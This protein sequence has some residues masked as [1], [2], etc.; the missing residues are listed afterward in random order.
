MLF[1]FLYAASSANAGEKFRIT[2]TNAVELPS[3]SSKEAP[4]DFLPSKIS[5]G[6][7]TEA[8]NLPVPSQPG[9]VRTPALDDW[10]DRKKNWMFDTPNSLDRDQ[11]M[12]EIFGVR[13]Y[14][15]TGMEKKP[16]S[17]IQQFLE[18]DNDKKNGTNS[19]RSPDDGSMARDPLAKQH[20]I[21]SSGRYNERPE[22]QKSESVGIIPALNPAYLF[23]WR[24]G[25]DSLSQTPVE[26]GWTSVLPPALGDQGFAQKVPNTPNK[27]STQGSR[28]GGQPWDLQKMPLG[29]LNDPINDQLDGTR[30]PLNPIGAR[31]TTV[32]LGEPA[33][34]GS[35]DTLAVG[36]IAPVSSHP[37][38]FPANRSLPTA[39]SFVPSAA[40]PAQAPLV[41]ARPAV[42]DIPRPRF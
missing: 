8:P 12:H 18:S 3:D 39:P 9:L 6:E 29:R 41:Q 30:Y 2:G 16:K 20:E 5:P 35:G 21:D 11:A 27:E 42:L 4:R 38:L 14:E 22:T 31:K 19:K 40:S 23:N 33:R 24:V 28:I 15:F 25:P 34:A 1:A 13:D 37:D 17:R 7:G 10:L 36:N 32:P 26:V